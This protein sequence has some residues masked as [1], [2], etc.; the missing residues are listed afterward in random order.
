MK[1][2]MSIQN[3]VGAMWS[4]M[5]MIMLGPALILLSGARVCPRPVTIKLRVLENVPRFILG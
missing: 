3:I 1:D 2:R 5:K 4:Q